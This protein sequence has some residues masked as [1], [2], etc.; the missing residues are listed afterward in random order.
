MMDS[1]IVVS[2][3]STPSHHDFFV[4]DTTMIK[5]YFTPL[6]IDINSYLIIDYR[7]L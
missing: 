5:A 1:E 4:D 2:I 7:L 3:T 6:S